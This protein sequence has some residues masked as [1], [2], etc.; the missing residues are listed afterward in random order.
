MTLLHVLIIVTCFSIP[1]DSVQ[2]CTQGFQDCKRKICVEAMTSEYSQQSNRSAR[3]IIRTYVVD[4][5]PKYNIHRHSMTYIRTNIHI[6]W[7]TASCIGQAGQW[8]STKQ[9]QERWFDQATREPGT[10]CR[11]GSEWFL[12]QAA[13]SVP[14]IVT[15]G[16]QQLPATSTSLIFQGCGNHSCLSGHV[17]WDIH[18]TTFRHLL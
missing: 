1:D 2:P 14:T 6:R 15:G 9:K 16:A 3:N 7:T 4:W 8:A 10:N 11:H 18:L 13:R 12:D 17:F 5:S